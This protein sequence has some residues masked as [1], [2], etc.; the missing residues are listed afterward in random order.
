MP[1]RRQ[2]IPQAT[3]DLLVELRLRLQERRGHPLEVKKAWYEE[4][5]AKCGPRTAQLVLWM[6]ETVPEALEDAQRNGTTPT[7]Q[8]QTQAESRVA[9]P[10]KTP[11]P[12][13]AGLDYYLNRST[14]WR[15]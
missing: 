10:V 8:P 7:N 13:G 1:P 3:F 5:K 12:E 4:A 2:D 6:I 15:Q 11:E 9:D 14:R